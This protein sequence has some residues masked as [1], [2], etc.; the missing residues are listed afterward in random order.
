LARRIFL[1]KPFLISIVVIVLYTLAGFFLAPYLAKRQLANYAADQLGRQL[2]IVKLRM[3]PYALTLEISGLTLKEVDASPILSFDRLFVNFE[4]KSLFR[5]AWTFA[6]ISLNRPILHIDIHPDGVVNLAQLLEDATPHKPDTKD[7][8]QQKPEEEVKPP[9]LYF[10]RIA[11]TEGHLRF[12]DRSDPTPA[13]ATLEP[14]NLA[15]MDLTTIP[16]LKGPKTIKATLPQG[17]TVEWK[18]EISLHPIASEGEFTLHDMKLATAWHFLQDELNLEKPDGAVDVRARY[19]FSYG[20]KTPQL[21]V[22]QIQVLL[23][24][25]LLRLEGSEDPSLALERINL[26][27]G[28][29]D[30]AS[31]ELTVGHLDVTRGKVAVGIDEDG[32]LNWENL[33]AAE[34]TPGK[35]SQMAA[36][37]QA[38]RFRLVLKSV[39]VD[40]MAVSYLDRSRAEPIGFNLGQFGLKLS[41]EVKKETETLQALV[42]DITVSIS[43]LTGQQID[44]D[45]RLFNVKQISLRGGQ[46][47]LAKREA[48]I[49]EVA[50]SEGDVEVW[51]DREGTINWIRLSSGKN[52]GAIKSEAKEIQA[53]SISEGR[54]WSLLLSNMRVEKFG[55]RLSDR[56]LQS[57]KVYNFQ[58]IRLHVKDF[59]NDPDSLF[60]FDLGLDVA[61]G[62]SAFL[63]GAINAF[64]PSAE[65]SLDIKSVALSPLQPYLDRVARLSLDSGNVSV[66]GNFLYGITGP[67]SMRFKGEAAV[68][69][70]LL[71]LIETKEP[72]IAWKSLVAKETDFRMTPNEVVVKEVFFKEPS[73][74]LVIR[75]DQTINIQDIVVAGDKGEKAETKSEG[76]PFKIERVRLEEA[77]LDF[78]DLSLT[79]Q[80]AAKIHELNGAVAGLSSDPKSRA[81]MELEGR[82]DEYGSAKIKGELQPFEAK[83][84]SDVTMIFRNVEMTNLTPYTATFAGRKITSGKLSLDLSYRINNSQLEGKNQIIMD[85]FVLGERVEGPKVMD[86]PLD[87]AIALLKDAN[88]RIDIGLPVSGNLDDPKFSYGDLIWKAISNLVTKIATAP[89]RAL[90]SIVGTEEEALDTIA[91]EAGSANLPPPEA[92]KLAL[93]SKALRQ[94]PQL[95]LEVQGQ[96]EPKSDGHV[97][98]ASAVR[99]E[100][101]ALMGL[102]L[103]P[104]QDPGPLSFTDP[105]TQQA[106]DSIAVKR[107]TSEALTAL[108]KKFGMTLSEQAKPAA[109][110]AKK[111]PGEEPPSPDP[112]G[113]YGEV[114]K[115]LVDKEPLD[116]SVFK[117]LAQKRANAIIAELTTAGGVDAFRVTALEP[118]QAKEAE[119]QVVISKLNIKAR[120]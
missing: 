89:F 49:E 31:R 46:V 83:N 61:E 4:L 95:A 40:D 120:K 6:E 15:I 69:W 23:S 20:Q 113:F 80:F 72:F 112:T 119:G 56:S 101:A 98:K 35:E 68:N 7:V 48:K 91:Y 34:P 28:R 94:R 8:P 9:R 71:A 19:R 103:Q 14:I 66:K 37:E 99:R 2:S 79:P 117:G 58:N 63:K 30:L 50:I 45:E 41:A 42:G 92:E 12:T 74:K 29:F 17:G 97:L 27:D 108:R 32:R 65:V 11:L 82:V 96:Y 36:A 38:D 22:D 77:K 90:A 88:D 104:N 43:D 73:G 102:S 51:R 116:Q 64:K 55:M 47:D 18:G 114:F 53:K 76:F 25:I 26:S 60:N 54:P 87:L 81:A 62:G 109:P 84:Y 5:W 16:E 111:K 106:I 3:N 75:E 78:A 86:L 107:L 39:T 105:A 67:K 44:K 33:V 59:Q 1:S 24:T 13:E 70:L 115:Q 57:P 52:V 110:S 85:S 118:V 93:L 10:E 21:T 100:L